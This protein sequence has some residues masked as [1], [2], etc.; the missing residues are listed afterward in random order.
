MTYTNLVHDGDA[1][2]LG[3]G[4][5]L[6]HGGGDIAGGNDVLLLADSRLDDGS[7]EGVGD[8]ADDEIVL[9]NLSIESLVVGD[10]ERDGGGVLD[11][12]GEL[13]SRGKSTAGCCALQVSRKCTF[14]RLLSRC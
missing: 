3:L 12:L 11:A 6:H 9:G 2:G 5:E 13:L 8:Q 10:I 1:G 4:I 7:V 14:Y